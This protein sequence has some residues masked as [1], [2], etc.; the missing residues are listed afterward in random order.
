MMKRMKKQHL[1]HGLLHL[2][3]E[4]IL[5]KNLLSQRNTSIDLYKNNC[6][7]DACNTADITDWQIERVIN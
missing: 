1:C 7:R 2:R 5:A 3:V 6:F 4:D